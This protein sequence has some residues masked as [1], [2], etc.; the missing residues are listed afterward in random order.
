MADLLNTIWDGSSRTS[1]W[2]MV[3]KLA[4]KPKLKTFQITL[5]LYN[6]DKIQL[7]LACR[8]E[9]F[10]ESFKELQ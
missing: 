3:S 1:F 10:S 9:I 2:K 4:I 7:F 5:K 8:N 6:Q